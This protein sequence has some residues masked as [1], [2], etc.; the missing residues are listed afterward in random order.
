MTQCWREGPGWNRTDGNS[1]CLSLPGR[2]VQVPSKPKGAGIAAGPEGAPAG[3]G[4]GGRVAVSLSKGTR[5]RPAAGEVRA[6]V[7]GWPSEPAEPQVLAAWD[8]A[9][10]EGCLCE[11]WGLGWVCSG[12]SGGKRPALPFSHRPPGAAGAAQVL[13]VQGG[14][15]RNF[16]TQ[17]TLQGDLTGEVL[18]PSHRYCSRWDGG[19]Q[20]ALVRP[21]GQPHKAAPR[22]K[23][24]A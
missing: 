2:G 11:G 13:P 17:V 18:P 19:S 15:L 22:R 21:A 7:L 12:L 16:S 5:E 20:G 1:F 8:G 24:R 23:A 6:K 10:S 14:S 4:R 3:T 9:S